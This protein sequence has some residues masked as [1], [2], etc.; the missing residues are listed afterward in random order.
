MNVLLHV[1]AGIFGITL[2][3]GLVDGFHLVEDIPVGDDLT[4]RGTPQA[5]TAVMKI[6]QKF[7]QNRVVRRLKDDA[8]EPCFELYQT[9]VPVLA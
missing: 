4:Q 9:M 2:F 8:M 5:R 6:I 1:K 7:F 3:Q